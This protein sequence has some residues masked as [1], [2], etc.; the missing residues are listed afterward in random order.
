MFAKE[1]SIR[2]IL[3]FEKRRKSADADADADADKERYLK[4]LN[5]ACRIP[6][7]VQLL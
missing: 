1:A 3:N 4:Y 2:R 5:G 6:E 7:E